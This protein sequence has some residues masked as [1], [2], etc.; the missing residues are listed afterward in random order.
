MNYCGNRA[1]KICLML[2]SCCVCTDCKIS[3]DEITFHNVINKIN[4]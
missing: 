4:T 3:S 2:K 1:V